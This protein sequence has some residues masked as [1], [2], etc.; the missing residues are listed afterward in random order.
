MMSLGHIGWKNPSSGESEHH[1]ID[2]VT[3]PY[4]RRLA[5][6]TRFTKNKQKS[7]IRPSELE[8]MV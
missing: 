4:I 3:A 8:F 6:K 7:L 5:K 1:E 2:T